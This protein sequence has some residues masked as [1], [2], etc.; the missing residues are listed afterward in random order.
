MKNQL[1]EHD[2]EAINLLR[3][4]NSGILSTISKK[5]SGYPFG[6]FVTYATGRSRIIYF[7]FSDLAQHTKNLNFKSE[8]CLTISETR[9]NDDKQNSKRLTLMGDLKLV[10][11]QNIKD[12]KKIFFSILPESEKYSKMHDFNFYQLEIKHARWI[13]GFGKISWLDSQD[14]AYMNPKWINM[15]DGIISHMNRDH[16]NS[17][18]S[19]LN[20]QY[21]IKDKEAKML[22][23]NVD[24]YYTSSKSGIYFIQFE[25]PCVSVKQYKNTLIELANKY[26]KYEI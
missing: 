10:E 21:G 26:K 12:C 13:G 2:N 1:N 18:S 25:C 7:Y 3:S 9:K 6:S 23:L 8:S 16:S 14:W 11:E 15:E 4:N 24:G 22:L 19:S 5:Y 20:A 17:I